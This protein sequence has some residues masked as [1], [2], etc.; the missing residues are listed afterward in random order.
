MKKSLLIFS[1]LLVLLNFSLAAQKDQIFEGKIPS[2]WQ[3]KKFDLSNSGYLAIFYIPD[4]PPLTL[5]AKPQ[6]AYLQVFN[7]EGKPLFDRILE[8]GGWFIGF[9][10]GDRILL[11]ENNQYGL[12]DQQ[13]LVQARFEDPY[14]GDRDVI[15]DLFGNELAL[16]P[17][18]GITSLPVSVIDLKTGKEKFRFGPIVSAKRQFKIDP[19]F[20]FLPVGKDDLYIM[21]FGN[22]LLLSRYKDGREIWQIKNVGGNIQ[23][24][25]FL[26]R[27]L[28]AVS[29]YDLEIPDKEKSKYGV[30]LIDWKT[31]RVVFRKEGFSMGNKL[32][33]WFR[34]IHLMRAFIDERGSLCF[35]SG[36]RLIKVPKIENKKWDVNRMKKYRI[37]FEEKPKE[38]QDKIS[39]NTD[40]T[41][42]ASKQKRPEIVRNEY[43]A[44][45]DGNLIR[46]KRIK[47]IEL[48]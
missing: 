23:I 40:E 12:L 26:N 2:G 1:S 37:H 8:P 34:I 28:I 15:Y 38:F 27:D 24:A 20:C 16:S 17:G 9:I 43:W 33:D 46:I 47:L 6:K 3:L 31:G 11:L 21:G 48:E 7:P 36:E 30:V 41:I 44:E 45:V 13:G 35:I 18:R 42:S 22:S 14:G 5:L 32:D 25:E 19:G 29:Y 10:P 4:L 39:P